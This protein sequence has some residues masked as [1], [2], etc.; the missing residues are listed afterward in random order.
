MRV[1]R[2]RSIESPPFSG[3]TWPSREEP[4]PNAVIGQAAAAHAVTIAWTSAVD[5]G[6]TTA[7]G[8]TPWWCDSPRL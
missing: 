6:K 3:T 4:A 8:S 5:V 7:S 2:D 1:I